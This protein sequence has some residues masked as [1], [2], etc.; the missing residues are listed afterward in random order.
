MKKEYHHANKARDATI[1]ENDEEEDME[2]INHLTGAGRDLKKLVKKTEK[3]EAYESD[4][5][6][7]NPYASVNIHAFYPFFQFSDFLLGGRGGR[8]TSSTCIG[9]AGCYESTT[10]TTTIPIFQQ[11]HPRSRSRSWVHAQ[12]STKPSN[13]NSRSCI[14][15]QTTSARRFFLCT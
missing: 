12:C 6:E 14:S 10:T 11:H 1:D 7:G 2:E 3:N 9:W 15:T 13:T 8:T 5:D 4:D